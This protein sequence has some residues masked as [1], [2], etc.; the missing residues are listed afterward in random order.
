MPV[1]PVFSARDRRLLG[2]KPAEWLTGG[3]SFNG[4]SATFETLTSRAHT[5]LMPRSAALN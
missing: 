4:A 1:E 2:Y 3:G 5:P